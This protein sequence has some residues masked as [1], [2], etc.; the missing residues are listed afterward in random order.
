[1]PELAPP[2]TRRERRSAGAAPAPEVSPVISSVGGGGLPLFLNRSRAGYGDV[3]SY[4]EQNARVGGSTRTV[5]KAPDIQ[6]EVNFDIRR[7]S[8]T[9]QALISLNDTELAEQAR[10][11]R[12]QMPTL[13]RGSEEYRGAVE[14]LRVVEAEVAR[15]TG[16]AA[17][18][19]VNIQ[20]GPPVPRPPGLPLETGYTLQAINLPDDVVSALPEGE[21]V[22][23]GRLA[24]I[25]DSSSAQARGGDGTPTR[26]AGGIRPSDI[27][28]PLASGGAAAWLNAGTTLETYGFNVQRQGMNLVAAGEDAIG[29]V[30]IPRWGTAGAQI[31]GS[32]SMWGHTALYVRVGGRIQIVR[33]YTIASIRALAQGPIITTPGAPTGAPTWNPREMLA[34]FSAV[35]HGRGGTPAQ[36]A[37]DIALFRNSGARALEVAVP[38]EVA[39]RQIAGLPEPGPV[40]H[41]GQPGLYTAEPANLGGCVGTN[42]V[43]WA[44]AE[45]ER[46][47]GRPIGPA[48]RPGVSVSALGPDGTTAPGTG[49]QGRALAFM[50]AVEQG[51]EGVAAIPETGGAV[52]QSMPRALRV[53]RVGGR[54]FLALGFVV[55]GAEIFVAPPEQRARTAVGVGGGFVGGLALGAAAGLVCGPGAL[56][57]SVVLGLGFGLAGAFAGRDLSER[58]YDT[59]TGNTPPAEPPRYNTCPGQAACHTPSSAYRNDRPRFDLHEPTTFGPRPRQLSDADLAAI[60]SWIER[61]PAGRPG[62]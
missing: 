52:A 11:V 25:I 39:L 33:G 44:A 30:S 41:G 48:S 42:C 28:T 12:E 47:L 17:N 32:A 50:E 16:L 20:R 22:P 9:S 45:A 35:R 3:P 15:R 46:T 40:M 56:V 54:A 55:G 18:F 13:E 34:N 4:G 23:V 1:M 5:A 8:V 27:G 7:T 36:I 62:E 57:C 14:N 59:A 21:L 51:S 60:Q 37:D 31:P 53:L 24:A 19:A 2:V 49:S 10:V 29:L 38:R 58:A 43:N 6:R 26:P 61:S